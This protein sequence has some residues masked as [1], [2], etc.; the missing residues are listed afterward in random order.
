[1]DIPI[2]A[3]NLSDQKQSVQPIEQVAHHPHT[4]SSKI[5]FIFVVILLSIGSYMLGYYQ[6]GKSIQN[7][8]SNTVETGER[9]A[10]ERQVQEI[11]SPPILQTENW[12]SYDLPGE[13]LHVSYPPEWSLEEQADQ[14]TY[15]LIS[16]G[17]FR[18]TFQVG[19]DG[20]GGGCDEECAS[21]NIPNQ[22]LA[23]LRFY[24]KPLFVVLNGMKEGY[25]NTAPSI[26]F[27]VLE[28]EKCFT[29]ICY[30]FKGKHTSGTMMITGDYGK[31]MTAD[32]FVNSDDVKVALSILKTIAYNN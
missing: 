7:K 22:T 31:Y 17:K 8:S 12:K 1:M 15:T 28:D 20:L 2:E 29:N 10:A 23:Q 14:S 24:D 13:K 19:L 32:Q 9:K 21:Y 5:F 3:T 18:L 30:G 11:P 26:R 27:N 6:A 25:Y 4:I 16:P